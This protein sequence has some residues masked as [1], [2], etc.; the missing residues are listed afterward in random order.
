LLALAVG[1]WLAFSGWHCGAD[2]AGE[3]G[4]H[5]DSAAGHPV[6]LPK[7]L[8]KEFGLEVTMLGG[9]PGNQDTRLL[10]AD[11]MVRFRIK[12]DTKAYV[13]V[14]TVEADGTIS[15][16]FPN[17][18]ETDSLFQ[19]GKERIVPQIGARA[20]PSHGIDRV[21]VVASTTAWKMDDGQRLGPIR[22]FHPEQ[23]TRGLR[24]SRLSE[25]V[26]KYVVK[27]RP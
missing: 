5:E 10:T 25:Q 24:L 26:L 7:K 17:T 12:V 18:E 15:Q 3:P 4:S 23:K 16:L 21:L 14:W 13:G 11:D 1:A 22:L 20:V 19:P 2:T 27:P 9:Q 8:R 6:E